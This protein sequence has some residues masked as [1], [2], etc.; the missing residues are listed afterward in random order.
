MP[1]NA[2]VENVVGRSVTYSWDAI[3]CGERH[4]GEPISYPYVIKKDGDVVRSGETTDLEVTESDVPCGLFTFE[5]AA[6]N[7]AGT[8]AY[9]SLI[10]YNLVSAGK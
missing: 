8:G 10:P 2:R 5:V 3:I 1:T 4:S 7:S 9:I 6:K